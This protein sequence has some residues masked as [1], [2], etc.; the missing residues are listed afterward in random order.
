MILGVSLPVVDINLGQAGNEE[1]EFL[2]VEDCDQF[3]RDDIVES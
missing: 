2:L 3:G 1:F